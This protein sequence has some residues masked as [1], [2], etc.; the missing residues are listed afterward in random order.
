M[1]LDAYTAAHR[2]EWERLDELARR[3]R[4][5]GVEADELIDRYQT[6]ASQLSA[7]KTVAGSTR[8]GD[9]LSVTLSRARGRFTAASG[10]ALALLP[11][12]FVLQLPAA[13][14]RLRWLTL[15]VALATAIV[16]LLYG[17]WAGNDPRVLANFGSDRQLSQMAN[18][19]FIA[20]YSENPAASFAGR[21]WTNNAF[22]AAQCV[23]FG[24]TGVW[25]PYVVLQNA[26][27]LGV[28]GAV[29]FAYDKGDAF[30]LFIAPHGQLELT[31]IFVAAA[32]GL[33][34]FWAWIAPGRFTRLESLAREGRALVTVAIGL[35]I[36]LFVSGIIEGFVTPW[37]LQEQLA[38]WLG[39][40]IKIGI[41]SLA[42]AAF[43][44]YM[45]VVG[46]RAYRAG[47]TGDLT[48]FEAGAQRLTAA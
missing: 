22:I 8:T 5:D 18:D 15:A 12:F 26:Q 39:W 31:S 27:N 17:F 42:L 38:P 46:G 19:Q 43:L 9:R 23:A 40:S 10:N 47:E 4:L 13:L 35:V 28:T 7:I 30:F 34:I 24:I 25:V 32:A 3:G 16:A 44:C 21:V 29:M 45:L 20:Y 6:G 11:R 48:E 2:D 14:Y 33:R 36:A 37:P 41:G 1:D